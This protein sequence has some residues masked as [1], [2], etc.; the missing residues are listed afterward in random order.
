MV[1]KMS[2][3]HVCMMAVACVCSLPS[4]ACEGTQLRCVSENKDKQHLSADLPAAA[5]IDVNGNNHMTVE[6]L[7]THERQT[8]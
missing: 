2:F 5:V 7:L 3:V 4:Q 1:T 8:A 6:E